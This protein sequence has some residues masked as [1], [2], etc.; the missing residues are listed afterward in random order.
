MCVMV[1][2]ICSPTAGA[3]P[4]T[5]PSDW[6]G[7]LNFYRTSAGVAGVTEDASL[8]APGFNHARYMVCT[9]TVTHS[10]DPSSPSFTLAGDT[11][12]RRSNLA[13]GLAGASGSEWIER[14]MG[15]P[16]HAVHLLDPRLKQVGF[17][18]SDVGPGDPCLGRVSWTSAA[19]IDVMSDVDWTQPM[20]PVVWPAQD[21]SI[22]LTHFT[23]ETPDPRLSCPGGAAAWQGIPLIG[24]FAQP[25]V[26]PLAWLEGPSGPLETC[27]VT[28]TNYVGPDQTWTD[29]ARSVMQTSNAV[30]V[31]PKAP[32]TVGVHHLGIVADWAASQSLNS[33]F[34]VTP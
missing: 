11:A 12:A 3:S 4:S 7:S 27:L 13:P 33:W 30:V 8:S 28:A 31:I 29:V 19:V 24:M 26:N 21:S 10:E 34:H 17:A 20:T 14:W 32:L 25:P 5:P 6:L 2:A 1:G 15:A 23:G 16:F 22:R 9:G 18:V